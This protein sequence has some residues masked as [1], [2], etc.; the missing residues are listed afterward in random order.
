MVRPGSDFRKNSRSGRLRAL[1]AS[2][3][4]GL[5]AF[6]ILFFLQSCRT[7]PTA[8]PAGEITFLSGP[9]TLVGE[10][11]LP[12]GQGPHPVVVFVH[13]DG[14]NDRTS[15]GTYVPIMDRLLR[16]GYATFA[17]DKPGTGQSTGQIDRDRLLEQR[18]RIVLDAIAMLK[19]RGDIDGQRIGLWGISQAGWVMPQ[20]LSRSEDVA[21]MIAVSCAGGPGVAQGAYLV[22]AQ[23]VC[24]GLDREDAARVEALL[25]AVEL[26]TTYDE[27]LDYKRQLEAYPVLGT[28]NELGLT[29]SPVPEEAWHPPNLD[30]E[31]FWDPMQVIE[32]TPIPILA[33]FGERDTQVDPLQGAEAYRTALERAGNPL[34][35]V[36]VI[37]GTDHTI[38]PSK[39]GCL[40]E[41]N[42]RPAIK[43]RIYPPEYLDL[44]EAWLRQM[45]K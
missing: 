16:A 17:W 29:M 24:A 30:G 36:E 43:A 7:S 35:R 5:C 33:V 1:L 45:Q 38:T 10:L 3:A 8:E 34:S 27:Y 9:F 44:I 22:A 6:L 19:Q 20:V 39:T 42:S 40:A 37:P 31:Y 25:V 15:G 18:S 13:G 23:A 2:K 14:P 12:A 28:L 4:P 26:A 41:R 32:K 11:R 21:F